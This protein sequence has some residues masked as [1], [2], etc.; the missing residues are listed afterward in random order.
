MSLPSNVL[1]RAV[2]LGNTNVELCSNDVKSFGNDSNEVKNV[3][4]IVIK[5]SVFDR[6]YFV[7]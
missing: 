4:K 1:D 3:L 7:N 6:D 5:F 2:K